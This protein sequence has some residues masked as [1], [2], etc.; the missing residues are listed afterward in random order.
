MHSQ[1]VVNP[2][3]VTRVHLVFDTVGSLDFYEMMLRSL[4]VKNNSSR[5][6]EPR[7]GNY[8]PEVVKFDKNWQPKLFIE[9]WRDNPVFKPHLQIDRQFFSP[10]LPRVPK[11]HR[12]ELAEILSKWRIEWEELVFHNDHRDATREL[13]N[14]PTDKQRAEYLLM[15]KKLRESVAA[16]ECTKP[17][18]KVLLKHSSMRV[19]SVIEAFS[20]MMYYECAWN[21]PRP[22]WGVPATGR[23]P[24]CFS[25]AG[26]HV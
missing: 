16:W 8:Q 10:L 7:L 18:H 9:S 13:V 6:V 26:I 22:T 21:S 19:V 24:P 2:S 12:A 11:E 25:I 5:P 17:N 20:L 3:N 23:G 14:M 15:T 4:M 1:Q